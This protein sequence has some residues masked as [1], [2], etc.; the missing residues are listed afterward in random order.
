MHR[1]ELQQVG[2]RYCIASGIIDMHQFDAR[3]SPEGPEHQ[4]TNPSKPINADPHSSPRSIEL[5]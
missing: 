1:I 5:C 4:A 3:P 2:R